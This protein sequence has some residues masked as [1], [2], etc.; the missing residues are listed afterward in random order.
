M[1]LARRFADDAVKAN[2]EIRWVERSDELVETLAPASWTTARVE[3]WLDWAD[4]LPTDLPPGAT[5]LG[6]DPQTAALL[7]GG[8]ARYADRIAAWGVALGLLEGAPDAE[9][10]RAELVAAMATGVFAP[11]RQ[12]PFGARVHP[13][14]ADTAAPPRADPSDVGSRTYEDAAAQLRAGRGLAATLPPRAVGR[15][16]AVAAAVLNCQGETCSSLADNEALARA[17]ASAREAG[18]SDGAIAGAIALGRAGFAL[19]TPSSAAVL[20]SLVA[21]LER[22]EAAAPTLRARAASTLAWE[23]SGLTLAFDA[24]DAGAAQLAAIAPRGALSLT[25][26]AWPDGFDAEGLEA[27]IELAFLTLD[28]ERRVGFLEHPAD[29]YR[30]SMARPVALTLAGLAELL[31]S[32]ALAYDSEPARSLAR[33]LYGTAA[34]AA[35]RSSEALGGCHAVGLCAFEDPEIALMLGGLSLGAAPWTGPVTIAETRDGACFRTLGEPALAAAAR[36]GVDQTSLRD[37]LIGRRSLEGAPQ[38]NPQTLAARG[39]TSHEIEATEAALSFASGLRTAFAPAVVGAGFVADVLG[40]PADALTDP[41]FDTLAQAGFPP[42]A[43]AAAEAYVL[44]APSLAEAD[45]PDALRSVL[46]GAGEAR[47]AA[48][49]AMTA[50]IEAEL[51]APA[52]LTVNLP[53]EVGPEAAAAALAEAAK[54]GVRAVRIA[55]AGAPADFALAIPAPAPEAIEVVRERIVERFVEVERSR[56]KLPDRRK[57]Y[58]QKASVGGHKVYLHTGEYEDGELGEIFIDMHKEGAAFRSLMNNFAIAI[59]IG[60]QYGVPLEE[61]VDAFVFTRFEPAGEVEGNEAIRAATS[62]LDYVF[63]ELGVSYL[64][65]NDLA[66]VDPRS[67]N[68]DGLGAGKGEGSEPQPFARFI[69]KG[70]SRGAAPDNLVFLPIGG[71]PG[72]PGRNADVCPA[73]G[74]LALVRKGQSLICQTCGERAPQAG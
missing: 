24:A 67:L 74:D 3:S 55:R 68:A 64:E 49:A 48:R 2:W 16:G 34:R 70:F 63:R 25:P 10:F 72:A 7:G 33:A 15:L 53:F 28:I 43:I 14:A 57:G 8:P 69:S 38:I 44:G 35:R 17:A 23:T 45:I 56:R 29:A 71:K 9:V 18:A 61:F 42:E 58:I 73:C 39:F 65:R 6:G 1:P 50:A 26:F 59:S 47:L 41:G 32:H 62:I 46:A 4:G 36:L 37:A 30:R 21:V 54:A 27:A 19:E 52:T 66:S 13:L 5:E 51:A 40:A 31:V 11:G 20:R 12:I 60:L 22:S